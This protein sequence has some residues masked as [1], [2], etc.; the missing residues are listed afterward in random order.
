MFLVTMTVFIL[1][2]AI[3][4]VLSQNHTKEDWS[5]FQEEVWQ[6]VEAYSEASHQRD[7]E[8]YL[9]FWHSDF[10]GWHNGDSMLTNYHQRANGLRYYFDNTTS[11]EYKLEPLEIQ[12]IAHG[13]AAIVHY[14]LRNV[15]EIKATG[16]KEPGLS[17]WTDYLLKKY[18]KWLLISDHGGSVRKDKTMS[19]KE[20]NNRIDYV[21]IPVTDV[22]E[23]KRFYGEIFGWEFVDYGP[24]YMSFNDGRLAG[25]F[26][27]ESNPKRGGVLVVFYATQLESI[28]MKVEDAGGKI[29][30]DIFDFPGGRRFHFTDSSGNEFAVWSDH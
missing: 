7:L 1:L 29:V 11:L 19:Q 9:S 3:P 20:N 8:K 17:Y 10:I 22:N 26:R 21:E 23:A 28:K 4:Q 18:G 2:I 27:K 15:L 25:G 30:K 16:N 6:T 24:D 12:V 5:M 13:N 14:K